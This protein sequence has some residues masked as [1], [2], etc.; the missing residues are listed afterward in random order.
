M[1]AWLANLSGSRSWE[2]FSRKE[3]G[4]Y[5]CLF[6]LVWNLGLLAVTVYML[7]NPQFEDS[8]EQEICSSCG[9]PRTVCASSKLG[10]IE[11][12]Q[13]VESGLL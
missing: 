1:K 4:L 10:D 11:N 6:F 13:G 5:F 3:P 7:R 8:R 12:Q 2:Y 9:Q